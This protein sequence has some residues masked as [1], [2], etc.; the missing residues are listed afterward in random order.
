MTAQ[1]MVFVLTGHANVTQASLDL[2][3]H[4][5][6]VQENVTIMDIVQM[7]FVIVDKVMEVMLVKPPFVQMTVTIM[8]NVLIENVIVELD[9][10]EMIAQLELVHQIVI[11]MVS[12][13]I[14][15]AN[16]I[17]DILDLIVLSVHVMLNVLEMD[18]VTMELV[19]VNQDS[20]EFLVHFLHAHHLVQEMEDVYQLELKWL[21]NVMQDL[22]DM[23]ALRKFVQM[24]ALHMEIVLREFAHVPMV[25]EEVIVPHVVQVMVKD[26]VE[27][28]NVLKG[29]VIAT[30]D[31]QAMVV[32]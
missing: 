15:H 16:A 3:V 9:L 14:I 30:Q 23:I 18:I 25:G 32:I 11:I 29:N 20:Q 26:A 31:G 28:E 5:L 12:V 24:I 10:L 27:M 22:K 17:V 7:V 19:S 4:F 8:V 13:L 2:I 1:I 6:N 21:V